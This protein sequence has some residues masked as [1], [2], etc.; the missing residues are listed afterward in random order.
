MI[1]S[2]C[3]SSARAA[4]DIELA[5]AGARISVVNERRAAHGDGRQV[6]VVA[7]ED[8][9]LHYACSPPPSTARF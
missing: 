7:R 5:H 4:G 2:D 6:A 9:P 8:A 1:E 3:L